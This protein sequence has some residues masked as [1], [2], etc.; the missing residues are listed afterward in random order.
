MNR[1]NRSA[2]LMII[3]CM[4]GGC[5]PEKRIAWSPDGSRA[6]VAT[7]TGLYLIDA[8]GKV[9]PPR[10][11]GTPTRCAWLPD[12]KQLLVVHA[13]KAAK[14]ADVEYVLDARRREVIEAHAKNVRERA[15]AFKEDWEH[16]KLDPANELSSGEEAAALLCLRD[17]HA[18]GMEEK[19][20]KTWVD[21]QTVEA[22]IW[23]LTTAAIEGDKFKE[24]KALFRSLDELHAPRVSP[25]GRH[26]TFLQN[27]AVSEI[28]NLA[29]F[30]VPLDGA[31]PPRI[32]AQ[33]VALGY[34]WSPD[35]RSL[36]YI[37]GTSDTQRGDGSIDLG[38]LTTITV[39]DQAGAL[40]KE[41][42]QRT[43]RVGLLFSRML[44]ARWLK[45]GR[46]VFSSVEVTLPATSRD[47]PQGWTLFVLDPRMPASVNRVL[48]R[49]FSESVEAGLA[50]FEISPDETRVLLPGTEGRVSLYEFASGNTLRLVDH[51]DPKGKLR[52]LP[53]WRGGSEVC[54][55]S[56]A[57][58]E[59]DKPA[60][61]EIYLWKDG[62]STCLSK[63]W[64]DEMR[65][66]WLTDE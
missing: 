61:P 34:D 26:A 11:S 5:L 41:W 51:A 40:L 4:L 3:L 60:S 33:S 6:A 54:F 56:A 8:T 66:G 55:V 53:S 59:G 18:E 28:E 48:G 39:A 63:N 49:D 21:L 36:V 14:W 46:L 16:F 62:K 22:T 9:L 50:L 65:E 13:T 37:R 35:S 1:M 17:R 42:A 38:S 31:A 2:S 57:A 64:P 45:D 23:K 44:G 52:S 43:D 58:E 30:V 19:L 20:G 47:M 24:Q 32:I 27:V 25:N 10:L 29:L 15:L 12:G 7:P